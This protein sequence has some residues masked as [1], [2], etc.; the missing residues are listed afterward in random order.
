MKA[1]R[2][3]YFLNILLLIGNIQS[4]EAQTIFSDEQIISINADGAYSVYAADLDNDGDIDVLSASSYDDKIAWYENDGLGNF[5]TEQIINTNADIAK[6]VYTADLDNDGDVDVLS[7]SVNDDKIAWYE[8]DGLGNF[9]N[10]QIIST[11]ADGA[12]SVYASDLDNDG[13]IDVLSASN[14]DDKIAWYENDGLGNFSNEQ[15]ISTNADGA[16]SV[17]ASD[18]DNDGDIDILSASDYDDKIAWYENLLDFNMS[19]Y[20]NNPP[21]L[22]SNTGSLQVTLS[23]LTY[24]PYTYIWNDGTNTFTGTSTTEDFIISDLA[25]GIYSIT[26][27]NIDGDEVIQTDIELTGIPGSFFEIIDITST[28]STNEF[29]NGSL[30]I[31]VDGGNA[32]YT[33]A[34]SNAASGNETIN[35]TISEESITINALNIITGFVWDNIKVGYSHDISLSGL[36]G[37]NGVHELSISYTFKSVFNSRFGCWRC[38]S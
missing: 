36:K 31:S 8:N 18:L 2:F 4:I 35:E 14:Y 21:C 11:N 24:P 15:I 19:V 34:W 25:A 16:L 9:S 6:S 37:T 3:I 10:E 1:L 7:A 27:T 20:E 28:N 12:L 17:Y 30:Q 22:G 23:G 5:S 32:P 29:N 13:D 38:Q 26:V 33:Y